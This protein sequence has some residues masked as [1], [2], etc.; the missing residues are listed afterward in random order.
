MKEEAKSSPIA[1]GGS[2]GVGPGGPVTHTS[3]VTSP[4]G[5]G[6]APHF[7]AFPRPRGW[8]GVGVVASPPARWVKCPKILMGRPKQQSRPYN[9]PGS[10][11]SAGFSLQSFP[12]SC[13]NKPTPDGPPRKGPISAAHRLSALSPKFPFCNPFPAWG[14]GTDSAHSFTRGHPLHPILAV[15]NWRRLL[16]G[17]CRQP[18]R[19]AK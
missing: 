7:G 11:V 4:R 3:L 10:G 19:P 6:S 8:E 16:R 14:R 18:A 13:L 15:P 17:F 5:H 9:R 1:P 12:K 2:R